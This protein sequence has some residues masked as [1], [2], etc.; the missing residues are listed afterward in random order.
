MMD[1]QTNDVLK[2]KLIEIKN[3]KAFIDDLLD[4]AEEDDH[5]GHLHRIYLDNASRSLHQAYSF[6]EETIKG[7]SHE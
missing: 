6:I 2:N 7:S 4:N 1:E 3:T 5:F